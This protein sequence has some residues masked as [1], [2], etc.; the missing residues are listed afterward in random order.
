[1]KNH[2][3]CVVCS[4]RVNLSYTEVYLFE[5]KDKEHEKK[6][7]KKKCLKDINDQIF[8]VVKFIDNLIIKLP[9]FTTNFINSLINC[10]IIQT[11]FT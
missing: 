7:R 11:N 10:K 6:R 4:V 1:M 3:N 8:A 9:S 2:N 5:K